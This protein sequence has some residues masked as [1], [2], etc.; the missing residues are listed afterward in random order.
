[1]HKV[2]V[3]TSPR[4]GATGSHGA[5]K[6]RGAPLRRFLVNHNWA[7]PWVFS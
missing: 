6:G 1:L 4:D 3:R 5:R 7:P 2:G